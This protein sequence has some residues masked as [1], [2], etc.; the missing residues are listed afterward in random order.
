MID[1]E[2][3]RKNTRTSENVTAE[4]QVHSNARRKSSTR[5]FMPARRCWNRDFEVTS[6]WLMSSVRSGGG[7]IAIPPV[8]V[9]EIVRLGLQGKQ[10][11]LPG[12][13]RAL[14]RFR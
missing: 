9:R 12:A 10:P 14:E 8:V 1:V 4:V 3:S 13:V 2:I 7:I 6:I 5:A 11:R